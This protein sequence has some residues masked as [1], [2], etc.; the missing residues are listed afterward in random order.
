MVSL[1]S[2]KKGFIATTRDAFKDCI[3]ECKVRNQKCIYILREENFHKQ[4][5]VILLKT[6]C[7]WRHILRIFVPL[8][9]AKILKKHV[10]SISYLVLVFLK[11]NSHSHGEFTE[12]LFLMQ[13][14]YTKFFE[15]IFFRTPFLAG[16]RKINKICQRK[17]KSSDRL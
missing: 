15:T 3:V 6:G 9:V 13:L 14:R 16:D 1:N 11:E 8:S 2:I 4:S 5:V 10:R 12:L 7:S 17:L